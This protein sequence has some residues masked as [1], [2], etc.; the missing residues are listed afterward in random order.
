M[1]VKTSSSVRSVDAILLYLLIRTILCTVVDC[2][3]DWCGPCDAVA[4]TLQRLFIDYDH[5][6]E[7]L[8]LATVSYTSDMT[9]SGGSPCGVSPLGDKIQAIIPAAAK[10]NLE[11]QGCLPLFLCL[12]V[13]SSNS[14]RVSKV[15]A[16]LTFLLV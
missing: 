7:R 15:S 14:L 10:L 13:S 2:H 3:Q 8:M 4:P 11:T 5:A 16:N 1:R 6:S 9:A 12:R